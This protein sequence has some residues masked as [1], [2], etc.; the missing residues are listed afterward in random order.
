LGASFRDGPITRS[1]AATIGG[2]CKGYQWCMRRCARAFRAAC[3][4]PPV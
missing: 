3:V 2:V 1:R 4:F